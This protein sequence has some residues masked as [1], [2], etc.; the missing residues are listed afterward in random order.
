MKRIAALIVLLL[1]VASFRCMAQIDAAQVTTIGRNVMSMEDYMLA[2][3]YFNQAIKAKPYLSEPYYL[4]ALAKLSLEDYEGT[5]ADCTLAIERNK[6]SPE[7]YR[8]RGYALQNLGKDS[9]AI[10][11]YNRGLEYN[12]EDKY[13][14]FYK[15]V[16]Q[17]ET[18]DFSGADSTLNLLLRLNPKMDEGYTARARLNMLRADTTAALNDIARSIELSGGTSVHPYMLRA[19][20]SVKRKDWGAALADMNEAIRIRPEEPD[21]YL[22]RAFIRYNSDD[23]FGAMADYNYTLELQPANLAALFNRGLLRYEVRDLDRAASDFEQV[24]KLDNSNFHA[25]YNLGLVNMERGQYRQALRDFEAISTRYPRFYP[26]IYAR[27]EALRNMGQTRAAVQLAHTAEEMV[28]KYVHNPDKYP[29]DRPAIQSGSANNSGH[30][31][32]EES[33]EEV[34]E[35]F[36]QLVTS[37]KS[38]QTPLTYSEQIKGHVQ[39]RDLRV[40]PEGEYFISF[41]APAHTLQGGAGY[42]RELDDLNSNRYID[43][44][45]YLTRV[46]ESTPQDYDSLFALSEQLEKKAADSTRAADWFALGVAKTMLKDF[47]GARHALDKAIE[48][49]PGFTAAYLERGY[50]RATEGDPKMLP[51]AVADYMEALKLNPTLSCVWLNIGNIHY[52]TGDLTSALEA[53]SQALA[54]D[55]DFG[56]ALY[57]RGI[58]YLRLG[59]KSQA[60]QDL[61]RAGELGILPSYNLLKRMR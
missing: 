28:R 21:N 31:R 24:L 22:N 32:G 5:V 25:R 44:T 7:N 14:L 49:M 20:I 53:Y 46:S 54:I 19:D 8:L 6:F 12:P 27:A 9:L 43:H 33:E 60:L 23:Y 39:N 56:D 2:I 11:D 47:E 35:R 45:L 15:G 18:K 41:A 52:R 42:F 34:M 57:N 30:D 26:A 61:R 37:D 50:G 29:L 36:N 13:F 40:E 1:A 59:N 51:A 17:T 58:T 48:I 3:Q 55:S 10:I 38:S 4:R 16:A